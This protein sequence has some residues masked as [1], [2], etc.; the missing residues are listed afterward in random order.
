MRSGD[1]CRLRERAFGVGRSLCGRAARQQSKYRLQS[2]GPV[3]VMLTCVRCGCFCV[4]KYLVVFT[5]PAF[6]AE[7]ASMI[8]SCLRIAAQMQQMHVW[9]AFA[10]WGDDEFLSHGAANPITPICDPDQAV[11][12]LLVLGINNLF[13]MSN[14]MLHK[15]QCL[16]VV[17]IFALLDLADAGCITGESGTILGRRH[18]SACQLYD[19]PV[20]CTRYEIL[21]M[22]RADLPLR[23]VVVVLV[24]L[25]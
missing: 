3:F 8:F 23:R 14:E 11:G 6:D 10:E 15:C 7:F 20:H 17:Q 19:P 9:G 22:C 25:R 1:L 12:I 5:T 16:V 2:R 13:P 4:H 24:P 18:G 21:M